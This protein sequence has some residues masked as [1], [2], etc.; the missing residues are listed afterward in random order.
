MLCQAQ[1]ARAARLLELRTAGAKIAAIGEYY[2]LRS[3]SSWAT[4]GGAICG[5]LGT[6]AVIAAFAW[7]GS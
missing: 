6:A 1:T 2:Q 4:Y 5:L 7:P 3:R